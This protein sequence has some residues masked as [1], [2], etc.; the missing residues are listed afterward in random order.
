MLQRHANVKWRTLLLLSASLFMFLGAATI[1][2]LSAP[3]KA[4]AAQAWNAPSPTGDVGSRPN[5]IK[6]ISCPTTSFCVAVDLEGNA[7]TWNGGTWH[8]ATKIDNSSRNPNIE[9]ISCPTTTFCM[10]VDHAGNA[11]SWNGG[12]WSTSASVDSYG[13]MSVSCS[14]SSFCEAVGF[15]GSDVS[16]NGSSWGSESITGHGNTLTSISCWGTDYC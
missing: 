1:P 7:A 9:S 5:A 14:S 11:I 16:W 3:T 8:A 13:F 6:S 12:T 4:S 2:I 15:N 10:A